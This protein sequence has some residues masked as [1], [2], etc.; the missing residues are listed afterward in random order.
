MEKF[1]ATTFS[2]S[3]PLGFPASDEERPK[4]RR[5]QLK[6]LPCSRP[7]KKTVFRHEATTTSFSKGQKWVNSEVKH[8]R[9]HGQGSARASSPEE[10]ERLQIPTSTSHSNHLPCIIDPHHERALLAAYPADQSPRLT[11]NANEHVHHSPAI[12]HHPQFGDSDSAR[13]DN[14]A[15]GSVGSLPTQPYESVHGRL[16]TYQPYSNNGSTS[17]SPP[18]HSFRPSVASHEGHPESHRQ[19]PLTDVQEAC[20]LRYFVEEISHWFDLC[21]EQR[22]FQLVVP[23]RARQ[24][25]H[26]LNAIFAVAARH[27]SRLPKYKTSRGILYHGQLLP[28]LSEHDAVEYMLKCIPALRHFHDVEDDE[29]RDSIIATAVILRQLEEIDDEEDSQET[30]D[31]EA[32]DN[33]PPQQVN[34][35]AIINAVLRSSASHTLSGRRSLVQAAY[36]MALRQE[37]YHSFTR[38]QPPQLI[39]PIDLWQSASNANKTV[40][41]TV[42]VARW[43]WKDGSEQEW[44]RLM[45]QQGHLERDILAKFQP[46]FQQ[47]ADKSKGE[48]FPTIWYGSNIEVTSIQQAIMA[49]SVLVAENPFLK[50]QSASRSSWRQAE[51]DVRGLL[52]E[53]CGIALCHPA[54]PPALL[55]AAIGIQLYGDFF[56]DRYERQALRGVVEKYRDARAWPVQRL[57]EMFRE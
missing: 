15:A 35:L 37:I 14:S 24:H 52:L 39:P 33:N 5:C 46:I 47:P 54:S 19:F 48:I 28:K 3:A 17:P 34:F 49:R 4:C 1:L 30:F 23:V 32:R 51:N 10:S 9:F 53:L 56:T 40:M 36:W 16:S 29:Y 25:P 38:K 57:L 44:V 55:N 11:H 27:L 31:G 8:F 50:S 22:H 18:L 2:I 41:H 21:D 6:L 45:D 26:L 42:Q 12:Q 13:R 20:L 43:R 7:A